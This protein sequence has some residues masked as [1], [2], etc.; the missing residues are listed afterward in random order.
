MGYL[1]RGG[2]QPSAGQQPSCWAEISLCQQEGQGGGTWGQLWGGRDTE[3]GQE[4]TEEDVGLSKLWEAGGWRWA[5][6]TVTH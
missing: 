6:K 5:G 1:T 4:G 3:A 2:R